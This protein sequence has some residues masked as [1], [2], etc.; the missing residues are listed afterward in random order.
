V[1]GLYAHEGLR[2]VEEAELVFRELPILVK[3]D[4]GQLVEGRADLVHFDGETWTVVD[5]K[6]GGAG[7]NEKDKRQVALYAHAL[8][9]AKNAPVL[10]ILV[11]I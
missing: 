7:F 8:Q 3:L 11:G 5:Y 4:D 1:R 6:T 10:A 2:K 9:V